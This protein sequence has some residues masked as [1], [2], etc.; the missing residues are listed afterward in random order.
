MSANVCS[1]SIEGNSRMRWTTVL[2]SRTGKPS[3]L[4]ITS[5]KYPQIC[6]NVAGCNKKGFTLIELLVVISIIAL[7]LAILIPV[8]RK[9]KLQAKY[10]LCANNQHQILVAIQSYAAENKYKL[11]PSTQ[12]NRYPDGIY[13]EMAPN[14]LVSFWGLGGLNGG[15]V[16]KYLGKYLPDHATFMCPVS[17]IQRGLQVLK[18][19]GDEPQKMYIEGDA[20]IASG[21]NCS[22]WLLWN[23]EGWETFGL[24]PADRGKH[25]LMV[26]DSLYFNSS[27]GGQSEWYFN[28]PCNKSYKNLWSWVV[29]D[30]VQ[31]IPNS[32][33]NAGYLDGHVER[34]STKNWKVVGQANRLGFPSKWN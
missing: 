4:K 20:G 28:H 17:P 30:S 27:L 12:G 21:L 3:S 32:Q 33:Q 11:P 16:G 31:N 13:W 34:T 26:A 18:N 29:N 5:N 8:L 10:V 15:Y 14:W 9:A 6:H 2:A 1:I 19:Q 25:T 22:Y 24:R 23:Y 7:L